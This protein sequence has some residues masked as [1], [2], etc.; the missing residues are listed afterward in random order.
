MEERI[1]FIGLVLEETCAAAR[2]NAVISQFQDMVTGRIGVPD[3]E[4]GMAV[5]GLIV[6]G[7]AVRIGALTARL[8]TLP[9]VTVKSAV[10]PA[11]ALAP[12]NGKEKNAHE[13]DA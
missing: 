5:I 7:S 2:V 6:R 3:H 8:G 1:G 4:T 12:V 9:G 13:T 11:R 10:T